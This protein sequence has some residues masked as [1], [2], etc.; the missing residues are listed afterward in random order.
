MVTQGRT[1]RA[2][3]LMELYNLRSRIN[4]EIVVI[5]A[6]I[7]AEAQVQIVVAETQLNRRRRRV[8]ECGTESGYANHRRI[9]KEPACQACKLAHAAY[10]RDRT[11]R[12][13]A[14]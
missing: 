5:E 4:A 13:K 1:A 11:R 8:A 3:R 9:K 6:E 12:A 2:R 14:S 7:N 10:E